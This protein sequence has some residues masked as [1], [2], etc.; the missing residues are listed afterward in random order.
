VTFEINADGILTVSAV[1]TATANK[2]E[3]TITNSKGRLTEEEIER[4]L[5]EAEEFAEEDKAT[6]ER[7][8]AKSA[9]QGYIFSLKTMMED[10]SSNER[11]DSADK[12]K[13]QDAMRAGNEWLESNPE[14][15][16]EEINDK[17][18]EIE[19]MCAPIIM[20]RNGQASDDDVD[21]HDID[22]L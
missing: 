15:S 8:S 20:G 5:R 19:A 12:E 22:E 21:E 9:F 3:I 18:Q 16:P 10:E 1:I 7:V 13:V 17:R 11:F 14:A 2:A 6:K 4:M